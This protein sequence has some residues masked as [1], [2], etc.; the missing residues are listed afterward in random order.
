MVEQVQRTEAEPPQEV[1][2][3]LRVLVVD[4]S[5][6]QRKMLSKILKKSGFEVFEAESGA[7]ALEFCEDFFFDVILSDWMM[8]EMT[9]VEFCRKLR[10]IDSQDYSYFILLTSKSDKNEV[11]QGL[12]AGADDFLTKPVHTGE[13]RARIRAGERILTMQRELSAKNALVEETL[14]ELRVAYEMIDAD[15]LDAKQLQHSLVSKRFR[16]FG[17]AQISLLL[18]SSGHVGGDLVGFFEAGTNQ[19]GLYSIDV[20][21]HGITSALM[22]ARLAGH[23][24]TSTPDQNLSL[25]HTAGDY[26]MVIPTHQ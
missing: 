20:S 19:V 8:P 4:D 3:V 16:D 22:T 7:D 18:R 12:E 26:Y 21:G 15:L 9:G 11:A 10:E 23:L 5:P 13:L 1:E 17:N 2:R 24:S 25:K 14:E 6:A